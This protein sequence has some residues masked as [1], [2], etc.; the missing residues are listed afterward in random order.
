MKLLSWL[1]KNLA[2][3]DAW[4]TV[5]PNA[6]AGR[7][8]LLDDEGYIKGGMGGK[9]NGQRIDLIPRKSGYGTPVSEV[10]SL[11]QSTPGFLRTD[12]YTLKAPENATKNDT[13]QTAKKEASN[14]PQNENNESRHEEISET[15]TGTAQYSLG[16]TLN[17]IKS[18]PFLSESQKEEISQKAIKLVNKTEK[19]TANLSSEQQ[20]EMMEMA[21][22]AARY[23]SEVEIYEAGIADGRTQ[24]KA[25]LADTKN[26]ALI[27]IA[28]LNA[29]FRFQDGTLETTP[30]R[31]A[32]VKVGTPMPEA[33]ANE[34]HANPDY[35]QKKGST[36]NCQT[37]VCAYEMRLRGYNV[38]AGLNNRVY[39]PQY[40]LSEDSRRAWCDP[41]TGL[42]PEAKP[43]T[44]KD[45]RGF[46]DTLTQNL[47][48]G[49]RYHVS[50]I[51]KKGGGH[52]M[53]MEKN[54]S[55]ELSI[56]DP[57]SGERTT[58]YDNINS[59]YLG[60]IDYNKGARRDNTTSPDYY[61]V[62]NL[63]PNPEIM[64][65]VLKKGGKQ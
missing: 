45:G 57:Q 8:V 55:G 30:E 34:G 56:Y 54:S 43:I 42:P 1:K 48:T 38:K 2:R 50:V 15:L 62:D 21:L 31:I 10:D 18:Y 20:A 12:R 7:P 51:F 61:R 17:A 11:N 9:F 5:H 28:P 16:L 6:G 63:I 64:D 23:Q 52:I 29:L 19:A 40:M 36:T 32:G 14:E 27:D 25:Y 37:C 39:G 4:I 24:Y 49:E 58:G 60:R 35:L 44:A 46:Y 3:D 65:A 53:T 26:K 22:S 41:R 13:S 33:R 59:R 47:K